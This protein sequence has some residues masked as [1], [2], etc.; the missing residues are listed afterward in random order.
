MKTTQK[1][2]TKKLNKDFNNLIRKNINTLTGE[3]YYERYEIY[4]FVSK[5]LKSIN[6]DKIYNELLYRIDNGENLNSVLLE[7]MDKNYDINTNLYNIKT[8]L[9]EFEY[10]DEFFHFFY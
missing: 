5:T 6:C 4:N 3:T 8:H 9:L 2:S 1:I 10:K 7:L